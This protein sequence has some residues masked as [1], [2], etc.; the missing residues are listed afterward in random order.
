MI[1]EKQIYSYLKCRAYTNEFQDIFPYNIEYKIFQN[2]M[3]SVFVY[4]L[5]NQSTSKID[6]YAYRSTVNE[7]NKHSNKNKLPQQITNDLNNTILKLNSLLNLLN[8]K[9][10]IPVFGPT[11][12]YTSYSNKT[13]KI[14][15]NAIYRDYEDGYIAY[16]LSPYNNRFEAL[17][18]PIPHLLYNELFQIIAK[19]LS[20]KPNLT[21]KCIY[22]FKDEYLLYDIKQ[23]SNKA[24]KRMQD[25]SLQLLTDTTP[26]FN[27]RYNC[28]YKKEC[29]L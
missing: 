12:H 20:N 24:I 28:K 17:N 5:K 26:L 14:N 22:P 9:E 15:N 10:K 19:T 27:C 2:V 23:T 25:I 7:F 8:L 11:V 6:S 16:Y 4:H 13:I 3:K 18:D 21:I 1:L 29:K